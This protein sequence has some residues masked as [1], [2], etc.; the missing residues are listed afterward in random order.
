MSA[1]EKAKKVE[2]EGS[3]SASE[4]KAR[5]VESDK[6]DSEC[7]NKSDGKLVHVDIDKE[8]TEGRP[9]LALLQNKSEEEAINNNGET[10]D[11][12]GNIS[13]RRSNQVFKP[14]DR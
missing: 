11:G 13:V 12:D 14:T 8:V 3:I 2:K 7:C 6:D 9:A 5:N 1:S 4:P 10:M